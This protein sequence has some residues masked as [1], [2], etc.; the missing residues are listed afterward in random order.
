MGLVRRDVPAMLSTVVGHRGPH[1]AHIRN[2]AR[3]E[4]VSFQ[5]EV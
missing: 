2:G 1:D 3:L 5:F 4:S